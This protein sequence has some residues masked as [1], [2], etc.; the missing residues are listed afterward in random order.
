MII[1]CAASGGVGSEFPLLFFGGFHF[2][3]RSDASHFIFLILEINFF[4]DLILLYI[5][6]YA[7]EHIPTSYGTIKCQRS[8]FASTKKSRFWNFIVRSQIEKTSD[9]KN[10]GKGEIREKGPK[11]G[12]KGEK[13]TSYNP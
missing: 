7:Y 8:E 4:L 5:E 6:N 10:A 2:F 13:R 11:R 1:G 3:W 9:L 12:L